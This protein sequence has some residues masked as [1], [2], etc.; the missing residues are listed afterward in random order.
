MS[1]LISLQKQI[2]F[3]YPN[4]EEATS[5]LNAIVDSEYRVTVTDYS[6]RMIRATGELNA[7]TEDDEYIL[8]AG[9]WTCVLFAY[10]VSGVNVDTAAQSV[11][12][13]INTGITN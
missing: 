8:L 10:Q 4:R 12:V 1:M 5:L 7:G 13:N 11:F 9:A 3:N 6:K 2:H